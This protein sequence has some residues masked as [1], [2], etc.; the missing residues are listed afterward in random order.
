MVIQEDLDHVVQAHALLSHAY[1]TGKDSEDLWKYL[2]SLRKQRGTEYSTKVF[3][4]AR[5]LLV[6]PIKERYS[7]KGYL[8]R[9]LY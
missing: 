9:E 5:K 4:S 8:D 6:K 7:F 2:S 3:R 1:N